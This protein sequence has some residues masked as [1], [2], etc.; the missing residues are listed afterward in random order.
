MPVQGQ[1]AH[2]L[3]HQW[4]IDHRHLIHD[5]QIALQRIRFFSGKA[6]AGLKLQ[7]PMNRLRGQT[8]GFG[9]TLG[10]ASGRRAKQALDVLGSQHAKDGIH[11]RCLAHARPASDH[12]GASTQGLRQRRLLMIGQ[13]RACLRLA[14]G[15]RL[16]GVDGGIVRRRVRQR[17][18]SRR[19]DF[20]RKFQPRQTD[21]NLA[22]NLIAC[23]LLARQRLI[24]RLA[25]DP[26]LDAQQSASDGEQLFL[27]ERAMPLAH[28]LSQGVIQSR[29]RAQQRFRGDAQ[30]ACDLIR[31]GEA[32]AL[33]IRGQA[34]GILAHALDRLLAIGLVNAHR[35]ARADAVRMQEHHDVPHNLLLLPG[36]LDQSPPLL[37]DARDLLQL[38]RL[39]LDDFKNLLA[40]FCDQLFRIA[41]AD[42]LDHAAAQILLDARLRRRR[43]AAQSIRVK[44]PSVLAILNPLALGR[45][46]LAGGHRRETPNHS[47]QIPMSLD[48]YAQ[49]RETGFFIVKGHP[50]DRPGNRFDW[51]GLRA[52]VH[53]GVIIPKRSRLGN[54]A[55]PTPDPL[56]GGNRS[57]VTCGRKDS[58]PSSEGAGVGSPKDPFGL[59]FPIAARSPVIDAHFSVL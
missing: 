59:V 45:Q 35:A 14:P 12:Q 38:R 28:C 49:H 18:N 11:Q 58:S 57:S 16:L 17:A 2:Q 37:A 3:V 25:Q 48:R 31:R 5:Q 50:L 6:F 46:P 22:P 43:D 54:R 8:G 13:S 41:R 39:R 4:H 30:L 15:D 47:D 51:G 52:V 10:C 32:D 7:Q 55:E 1:G 56:R 27:R 21:E 23:Q 53:G 34:I 29:R 19:D 24:Q 42:A 20:L 44:L 40:K 36:V 33:N 26:F 9:K